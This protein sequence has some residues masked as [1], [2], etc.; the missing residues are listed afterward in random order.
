M[1]C[2]WGK[3]MP[4]RDLS[5]RAQGIGIIVWCSFLAAAA[6]TT[7]AFAMLDPQSLALG[8]PPAWWTSRLA[9]YAIGFFFFWAIAAIASVLTLLMLST[10]RRQGE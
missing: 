1:Y 4:D 5:Q 6:A 2:I 10:R 3:R 9:V 7:V 8:S